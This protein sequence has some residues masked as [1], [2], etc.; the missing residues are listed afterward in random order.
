MADAGTPDAA[1]FCETAVEGN[2]D[3]AAETLFVPVPPALAPDVPV[4]LPEPPND[5]DNVWLM[6]MSCSRLF[7]FTS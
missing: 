4:V 1:V 5:V 6:L 2:A 7:T 3:P